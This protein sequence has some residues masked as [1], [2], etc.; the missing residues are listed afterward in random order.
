MSISAC[1]AHHSI[2]VARSSTRASR[3]FR[4]LAKIELVLACASQFFTD[5]MLEVR[6]PARAALSYPVRLRP[7]FADNS[8]E[9][10]EYAALS[11]AGRYTVPLL[12]C[13]LLSRT[14]L[15]EPQLR[16]YS[17]ALSASR[18]WGSRPVGRRGE[19]AIGGPVA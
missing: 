5:A 11:F 14:K 4:E 9:L 13:R 7:C 10:T 2:K 8:E 19:L 17:H 1:L 18:D 12:R 16:R 3:D 6:P 15:R